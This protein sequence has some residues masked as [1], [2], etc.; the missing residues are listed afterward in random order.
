MK[1]PPNRVEKRNGQQEGYQ[2]MCELCKSAFGGCG[3]G[4]GI[5]LRVNVLAE[6]VPDVLWHFEEDFYHFRVELSAGAT[7]D[8]GPRCRER[9]RRTIGTVRADRIQSI[10]DGKDSRSKRNFIAL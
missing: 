2:A 8:L 7:A 5:N 1:L 3:V 6:I 10:G 4:D 9:L